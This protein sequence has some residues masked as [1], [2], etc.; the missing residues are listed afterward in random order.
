VSGKFFPSK[1]SGTFAALT[2]ARSLANLA[3]NMG[4]GGIMYIQR[5]MEATLA[6]SEKLFGA[7]LVTGAR[8]AG[9][10][11]LL[12]KLKPDLGYFSLDDPVLLRSALEEPGTLQL[13]CAN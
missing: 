12:K 6:K 2:E 4:L 10:T 9:K 11:T 5:H 7:V 1:N 13:P 8:Q 3:L